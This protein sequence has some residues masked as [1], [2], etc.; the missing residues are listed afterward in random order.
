[1]SAEAEAGPVTPVVGKRLCVVIP[2]L[3]EAAT[4]ESVIRTIP[5]EIPGI[6]QVQVVVI[7]DGSSDGTGEIA[8][9]AG[10]RVVRHPEPTGVGRAFRS[11][12][13]AGLDSGADVIVTMDGDGQFDPADIPALIAPV[14]S[15]VADF[16]TC[17]RFL[18]RSLTPRMPWAKRAGNAAVARIV[19]VL[20]GSR[21][22]DVA[23]GF[24]A[25]RR[26]A[27]MHLNLFG[28]FTYTQETFIDLAFKGLRIVEVP[29]RVKGEREF[30]ESRVASSLLRYAIRTSI[31]MMS[32]FKDYRP[33]V[34]FMVH[35]AV[36]ALPG[37]GLGSFFAWHFA[38]TGR[39]SPHLWAG[40]LSG[41]LLMVAFMFF[42]VAVTVESQQ[43]IRMTLERILYVSK[44]TYYEDRNQV[45][46]G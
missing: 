22:T 40:F 20:L 24:R 36:L 41:A 12:L 39:F 42:M 2:A 10:A 38:T 25:F 31:I 1:M 44:R 23:C 29:L 33:F 43:R 14:L 9:R 34:F 5:E 6:E 27:A 16:A 45:D 30:G 8:R 26:E 19:N 46:R 7:D 4:I 21:F 28:D 11:G 17:S 18:D 13:E 15:G 35:A 32:A 37:L 3:D